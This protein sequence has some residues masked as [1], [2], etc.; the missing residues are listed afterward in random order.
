MSSST[1]TGQSQPRQTRRRIATRERLL[2]AARELL[3]ESGMQA[4]TV[5]RITERA[6]FTRG[7][8]YSNYA[9][10][11]DL[12]L[13]MFRRERDIM[14]DRAARAIDSELHDG[15]GEDDA[16]AL[17]RGID[18]FFAAQ[19][20]DRNWFLVHHEFISHSVRQR[21]IADVYEELWTQ[22][23]KELSGLIDRAITTLGR[24]LTMPVEHVTSLVMA[25]FEESMRQAFVSNTTEEFDPTTLRS[26]LATLLLA[27]SEPAGT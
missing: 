18:H 22:T 5:E 16:T 13:D 9:T 6:G 8:F 2:E 4:A 14:L 3:A 21:D 11:D 15:S 27:L 7:A 17:M 10:M 26:L 24:R 19:P 25:I 23:H 20:T 1:T 12:I